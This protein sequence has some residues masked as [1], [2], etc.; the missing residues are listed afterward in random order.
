MK[1]TRIR[2]HNFRSIIDADI[3]AHDFLILVGANNAGKSNV[4]NA[5]RC[6]YEDLK[7]TEDDFPKK[8]G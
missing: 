3:E 4:I 1:L 5:L 8:R 7:G 6:F 2:I